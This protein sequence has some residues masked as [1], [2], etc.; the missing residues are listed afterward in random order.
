MEGGI[1]IHFWPVRLECH[2]YNGCI[3]RREAT[4]YITGADFSQ[5]QGL[6]TCPVCVALADSKA[7][8][9]HEARPPEA[10]DDDM[11]K[12]GHCGDDA[13]YQDGDAETETYL[14]HTHAASVALGWM[15]EAG[16][17]S[18]VDY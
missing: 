7:G 9:D 6:I 4:P 11:V 16:H 12:C 14:C 2:I 1:Y 10:P 3:E 13:E 18:A 17:F 8:A 5:I 15:L